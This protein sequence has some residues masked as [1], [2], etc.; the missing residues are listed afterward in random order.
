ME[1]EETDRAENSRE[2]EDVAAALRGGPEHG[3]RRREG[4]PAGEALVGGGGGGATRSDRS[5]RER[6]PF[7]ERNELERMDH[8]GAPAGRPK[9]PE[10]D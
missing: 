5:T 7:A 1:Q 4:E 8:K 9:E 10:D 3:A 6:L 2:S